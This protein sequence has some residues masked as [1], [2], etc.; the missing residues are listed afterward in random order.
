MIEQLIGAQFA[1]GEEW[2]KNSRKKEEME[3]KWKQHPD[4][5]VPGDGSKV[6][7]YK[8]Q[9]CLGTRNVR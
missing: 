3:P 5:D 1:N 8:K 2:R 4:V 7:C 9:N 6:Q